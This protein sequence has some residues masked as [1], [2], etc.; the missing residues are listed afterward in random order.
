MF[1]LILHTE[2]PAAAIEV[3]TT[4]THEL[5]DMCREQL[6]HGQALQKTLCLLIENGT[7][8]VNS[9]KHQTLQDGTST[10]TKISIIIKSQN[11][12]IPC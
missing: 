9:N 7:K 10:V 4:H 5:L 2:M 3:C 1:L 6:G 8:F 12:F 11:A